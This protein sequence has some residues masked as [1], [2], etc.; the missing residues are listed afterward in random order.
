MTESPQPPTTSPEAPEEGSV[1][2]VTPIENSK[3]TLLVPTQNPNLDFG[4][5]DAGSV[6]AW[7]IKG[8]DYKE[9]DARDAQIAVRQSNQRIEKL[10]KEKDEK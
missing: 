5:K 2:Q 8:G 9:G 1:E 10:N 7:G 4:G 6:T 3:D